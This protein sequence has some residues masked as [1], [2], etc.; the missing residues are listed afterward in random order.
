[1]NYF[2]FFLAFGF[3]RFSVEPVAPIAALRHFANPYCCGFAIRTFTTN[4]A[5]SKIQQNHGLI[6]LVLFWQLYHFSFRKHPHA[7]LE[8]G[9]SHYKTLTAACAGSTGESQSS[10]EIVNCTSTLVLPLA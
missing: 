5:K 9:N 4:S 8:G 2:R 10:D 7:P 6:A 1:M 3:R